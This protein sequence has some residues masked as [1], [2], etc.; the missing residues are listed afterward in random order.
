MTELEIPQAVQIPEWDGPETQTLT[1]HGYKY[2]I[3]GVIFESRDL[4]PFDLSLRGMTIDYSINGDG[5]ILDFLKHMRAVLSA[6]LSYPVILSPE[7]VLLD[8]RH[9]VARAIHEGKTTIRA[10]RFGKEPKSRT[11]VDN[12]D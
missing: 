9:R 12:E 8:G 2:D 6:D 11:R 3:A 4:E 7:G 5:R 10:V 1:L